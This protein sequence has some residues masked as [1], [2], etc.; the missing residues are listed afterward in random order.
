[1]VHHVG[2]TA[3]LD[4]FPARLGIKPLALACRGAVNLV[5]EV[6]AVDAGLVKRL[7]EA[8]DHLEDAIGDGKA[9]P[10][11]F[12][13]VHAAAHGV[14]AN[15]VEIVRLGEKSI[16]LLREQLAAEVVP[17][18]PDMKKL[19][20]YR[21]EIEKSQSRLLGILGELRVQRQAAEAALAESGGKA[22]DV[23]LRVVR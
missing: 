12:L 19:R 17:D 9:R 23:R 15:L 5:R 3:A 7:D 2:A 20:R 10:Q 22:I 21:S 16:E 6:G 1:M 11:H 14:Q 8:L 4:P 13:A 18:G